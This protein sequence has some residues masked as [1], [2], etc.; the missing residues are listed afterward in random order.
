[1]N[2]R[3]PWSAF[4]ICSSKYRYRNAVITHLKTNKKKTILSVKLCNLHRA[5]RGLKVMPC[6]GSSQRTLFIISCSTFM[7]VVTLTASNDYHLIQLKV[8]RG[9]V[10]H[11]QSSVL[12]AVTKCVLNLR[13]DHK[14]GTLAQPRMKRC[15]YYSKNTTI[16][17]RTSCSL[18]LIY[19]KCISSASGLKKT[20]ISSD[21]T[22][23]Y[24]LVIY[25]KNHTL[26]YSVY[27]LAPQSEFM[28]IQ[29][30]GL[31]SVRLY[32]LNYTRY[33]NDVHNIWKR[34]S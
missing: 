27:V 17:S 13:N 28:V 9:L 1:M 30:D 12:V 24:F 10:I 29:K 25:S 34:R 20:K 18:S 19:V 7:A 6:K 3:W 33:V 4:G 16:R 32:F 26:L 21:C 11:F 31:S 14:Q 15:I 22:G 2:W 8:E 5:K 23:E